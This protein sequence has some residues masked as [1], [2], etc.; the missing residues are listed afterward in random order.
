[1]VILHIPLRIIINQILGIDLRQSRYWLCTYGHRSVS[2]RG[3][4]VEIFMNQI[5]MQQSCKIE[6]RWE[7]EH[8]VVFNLNSQLL[9]HLEFGDRCSQAQAAH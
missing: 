3:E 5:R 2:T 4:G 7:S 6:K 1:M 8:I 9:C